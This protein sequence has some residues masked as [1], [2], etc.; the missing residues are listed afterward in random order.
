[1]CV[2][3]GRHND[4]WRRR[5]VS[6]PLFFH[7]HTN[8]HHSFT[9]LFLCLGEWQDC[10]HS[11]VFCHTKQVPNETL[12]LIGWCWRQGCWNC[13]VFSISLN[14]FPPVSFK[15]LTQT[16][17]T[18][19]GQTVFLLMH[20]ACVDVCGID[21]QQLLK[22]MSSW[23]CHLSRIQKAWASSHNNRPLHQ[24]WW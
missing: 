15:T 3:N 10:S 16:N 22:T 1:M 13:C 5:Q 14:L 9:L 11:M 6:T 21:T 8:H 4:T 19:C 24:W 17:T 23:L 12:F 2:K 20:E 18:Q 7:K